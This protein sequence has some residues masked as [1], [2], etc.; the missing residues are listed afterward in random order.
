MQMK[1]TRNYISTGTWKRSIKIYRWWMDA[2]WYPCEPP[3]GEKQ[4]H[5]KLIQKRFPNGLK[6]ISDYTHSKGLKT[7]LWFVP[8][9]VYPGTWLAVNH[10]EWIL[11]GDRVGLLNL[12]NPEALAWVKKH[13]SNL[14]TEQGIDLYRQDMNFDPLPLLESKRRRRPSRHN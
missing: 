2:G 5:G 3:T 14:L 11:N 13:I 9:M 4:G 6:A 10:P 12:G 8:E 7:L 1:P